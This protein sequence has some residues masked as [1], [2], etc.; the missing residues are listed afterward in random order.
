MHNSKAYAAASATSPLAGTTIA[1]RDP[2]E[3]E[4]ANQARILIICIATHSSPAYMAPLAGD[5]RPRVPACR[6]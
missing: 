4:D 5:S 3:H 1:R 6:G 2:T